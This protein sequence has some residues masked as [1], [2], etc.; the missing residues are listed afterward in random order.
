M[1]CEATHRGREREKTENAFSGFIPLVPRKGFSPHIPASRLF[2]LFHPT[3]PQQI[4]QPLS[5]IAVN[6]R[7]LL[8]ARLIILSLENKACTPQQSE[9]H[10]YLKRFIAENYS[11]LSSF[12]LSSASEL[13]S[14]KVV[15]SRL[16]ATAGSSA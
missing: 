2:V 8:T 10:T 13:I 4:K 16:L 5:K 3:Q 6:E 7:A 11:P 12:A 1:G 14:P 9:M 15:F